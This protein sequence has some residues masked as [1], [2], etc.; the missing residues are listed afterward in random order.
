MLNSLSL[1][2]LTFVPSNLSQPMIQLLL[3]I[4]TKVL[5]TSLMT[6]LTKQKKSGIKKVKTRVEI[7]FSKKS[8]LGQTLP[9]EEEISLIVLGATGLSY[10]ERIFIGSVA[11]YIIKKCTMRCPRRSSIKIKKRSLLKLRFFIP[12]IQSTLV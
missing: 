5:K 11:D 7:C 12:Q 2:S 10:I 4:H 9:K 1:T 6:L 8:M 3:M